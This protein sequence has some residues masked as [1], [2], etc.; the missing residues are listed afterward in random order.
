ML[1]FVAEWEDFLLHK[2]VHLASNIDQSQ[3]KKLKYKSQPAK[4]SPTFP[5]MYV[6]IKGLIHVCIIWI[7]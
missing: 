1:F 6:Y 7:I 3:P 5:L 2:R 4:E